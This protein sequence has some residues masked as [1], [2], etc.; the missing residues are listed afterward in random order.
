MELV[1]AGLEVNRE[2][3]EFCCSQVFYLGFLLDREGLRPDPEKV[4]PVAEY[5]VPKNVKQLRRF[6][7]M[8]GWYLRFIKGASG[9]KIP[10][11]KMLRKGREWSWGVEHDEA[12]EQLKRALAAAPVLARLDFSQPFKV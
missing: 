9:F 7:G 5:P 3:S 1:G 8:L 11:V 6:L 10:L 12:F 4:A 2:K